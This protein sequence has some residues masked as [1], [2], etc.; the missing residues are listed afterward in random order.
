M[1]AICEVRLET[2]WEVIVFATEDKFEL[3][4]NRPSQVRE[5]VVSTT[6]SAQRK[7]LSLH[8][9]NRSTRKMV[10][11]GAESKLLSFDSLRWVFGAKRT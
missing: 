3:V 5:T 10:H 2:R 11:Q 7:G 1:T 4:G 9:Q 8:C 6:K